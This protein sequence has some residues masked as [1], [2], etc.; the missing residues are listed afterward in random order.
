MYQIGN[1]YVVHNHRKEFKCG[2]THINN[3]YAAK[4]LVN[5][6]I[7]KTIPNGNDIYFL[8]SL[9]RLSD[10]N[11]YK[12]LLDDKIIEIKNKRQMKK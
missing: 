9:K 3:Y 6:C 10:D 11:E 8:V 5:L 12:K 4:R 7:H 2:H 1:G